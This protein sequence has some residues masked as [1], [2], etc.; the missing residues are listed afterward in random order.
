[1]YR[2]DFMVVR[3]QLSMPQTKS[4]CVPSKALYAIMFLFLSRNVMLPSLGNNM[5]NLAQ[6]R[7]EK[8]PHANVECFL[9]WIESF[10]RMR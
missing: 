9:P 6:Q 3:T 8:E 5:I 10:D 4:F 7:P 1:M 2:Y